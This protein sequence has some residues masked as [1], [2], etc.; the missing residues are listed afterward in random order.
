MNGLAKKPEEVS[1]QP[2]PG[3]DAHDDGMEGR[4]DSDDDGKD[5]DQAQGRENDEGSPGPL[6]KSENES[7]RPQA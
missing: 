1:D 7:Q 6:G 4:L 5:S 2:A 3:P